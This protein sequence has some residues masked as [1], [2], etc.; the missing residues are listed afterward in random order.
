MPSFVTSEVFT[1]SH[2]LETKHRSFGSDE[3]T[4][5]DTIPIPMRCLMCVCQSTLDS[6]L[7]G[8][9]AVPRSCMRELAAHFQMLMSK[10]DGMRHELETLKYQLQNVDDV[11]K[12]RR[13]TVA[14]A[15]YP[16]VGGRF[17]LQY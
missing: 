7:G 9:S 16:G 11:T 12:F 5:V 1:C 3:S 6:S 10:P 15:G 8:L 2:V 17:V 4:I 14:L 13:A